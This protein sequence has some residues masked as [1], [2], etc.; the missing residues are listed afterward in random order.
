ML[1]SPLVFEILLITF[2]SIDVFLGV[3][4]FSQKEKDYRLFGVV[5]QMVAIV[6]IAYGV[7]VW[8]PNAHVFLCSEIIY[9]ACSTLMLFSL[10]LFANEYLEL[11]A[12]K[13]VQRLIL[14]AKLL[15]VADVLA[16]LSNLIHNFGI[17]YEATSTQA[18][19]FKVT[20]ST[21]VV[22]HSILN[23]AIFVLALACFTY[24][25]VKLPQEYRTKNMYAA[26]ALAV[27]MA[28]GTT[29][30]LI[31]DEFVGNGTNY[32]TLLFSISAYL[33][34]WFC[35]R[36]S[37]TEMLYFFKQCMYEN[38]EQSLILF[39]RKGKQIFFNKRAQ[40]CFSQF[41]LKEIRY[42]DEFIDKTGFDIC[43]QMSEKNGTAF[44]CLIEQAGKG[45][46]HRVEMRRLYNSS[47]KYLGMLFVI[48]NTSL[49]MDSLSGFLNYEAF[50]LSSSESGA[51]ADCTMVTAIDINAL[52]LINATRGRSG[53]DQCI[54]DLAVALQDEMP[55][56]TL[57][58]RG[59]EITFL[60]LTSDNDES[61]IRDSLESIKSKM[62]FDFQY[63]LA[64]VRKGSKKDLREAIASCSSALMQK[65]LL[66]A[67]ST[68]SA[69]LSSLIRALQ[70]CDTDTEEHVKRTQIMGREL[71]KRLGFTDEQQSNLSLLCLLHDIGKIGVPLEILNKPGRLTKEEFEVMKTHAEKGYHIANSS[72]ALQ[73][74]A[75]MIRHH[76][77]RWD[78][79]GYPDGLSQETIP[80][81]SRI[82]SVIDAYD[83]M[84]SNRCYRKAMSQQEA[85]DE[86]RKCAGSQFDPHIVS[87]FIEMLEQDRSLGVSEYDGTENNSSNF[88]L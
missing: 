66:D 45:V 10:L 76:H 86:L 36:Y 70:E 56:S 29:T 7:S 64:P 49:G 8:T 78:G 25:S 35:F 79:L 39:D 42:L 14:T 41:D 32:T 5:C 68:H 40:R 57:F 73:K 9:M 67:G 50:L 69:T 27:I 74:I 65:K 84:V 20:W 43:S 59:Q 46:P 61:A 34:Y 6:T 15:C 63:A 18:P 62:S 52:S 37:K 1:H 72:P 75:D 17:L 21:F 2:A 30:F 22:L 85:F 60:L 58:I 44:L 3:F 87:L 51:F 53:G 26:W 19:Y 47:N 4:Y 38:I 82:I 54:K 23:L 77:E 16:L 11:H 24:K 12:S 55:S 80:V 83:A 28:L 33:C 81:L 13:W 48:T 71:G 88:I 31:D